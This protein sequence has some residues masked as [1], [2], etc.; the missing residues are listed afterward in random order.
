MTDYD[1]G[2]PFTHLVELYPSN[3]VDCYNV[4][5]N[6]KRW[7]TRMGWSN[8]LE[9]LKKALPRRIKSLMACTLLAQS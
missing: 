2:T 7:K 1:T 6:G 4:W 3:P 5:L 9:G 8:V